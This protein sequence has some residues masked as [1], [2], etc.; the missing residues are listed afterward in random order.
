[1]MYD[2]DIKGHEYIAT[3]DLGCSKQPDQILSIHLFV[4]F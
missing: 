2:A 3:T 4:S 1:M